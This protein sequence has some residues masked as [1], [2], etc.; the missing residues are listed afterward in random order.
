[1]KNNSLTQKIIETTNLNGTVI[2]VFPKQNIFR[3][4]VTMYYTEFEEE[5]KT[6]EY[7]LANCPHFAHLQSAE[8]VELDGLVQIYS[9]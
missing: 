4:H 6:L 7:C 5:L 9:Q 8:H 1:M 3:F 2:S